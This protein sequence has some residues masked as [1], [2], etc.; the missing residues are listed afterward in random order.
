MTMQRAR[1]TNP[2]PWTWE[3]PTVI[4]VCVLLVMVLVVHLARAV[5]NLCSAGSWEFTPRSALFTSLPNILAGHADAGMPHRAAHAG[6]LQ[7]MVW[8]VTFESMTLAA[9]VLTLRSGLRRWGPGRIVGMASP[10]EAEQ[11][12]GRSRLRRSAGVIRPDLLRGMD[13]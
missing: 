12:L 13:R 9:V 6:D 11:L 1:R 2:Y 5:A 8:I 10:G 7:L 4:A 3:V